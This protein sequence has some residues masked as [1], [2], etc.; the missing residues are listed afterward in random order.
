MECPSRAQ[1][2]RTPPSAPPPCRYRRGARPHP[3]SRPRWSIRPA[4]SRSPVRPSS[5]RRRAHARTRFRNRRKPAHPRLR[6]PP[7]HGERLIPRHLPVPASE[8]AGEPAA[9]R[10]QRR[11]SHCRQNP[12]R[13]GIERLAM[14]NGAPPSCRARKRSAFSRCVGRPYPF[15]KCPRS[16]KRDY[17]LGGYNSV[18]VWQNQSSRSAFS[19]PS[20]IKFIAHPASAFASSI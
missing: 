10:G 4:R 15:M 5:P 8:R 20:R 11:E 19:I 16:T 13:T 17:T 7:A 3:G 18:T 6:P 1:P 9:G 12:R 2:R 14:T